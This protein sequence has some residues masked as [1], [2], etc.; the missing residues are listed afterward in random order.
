M[1]SFL[2]KTIFPCYFLDWFI[3]G[4]STWSGGDAWCATAIFFDFYLNALYPLLLI[5]LCVIL[6]TR[7]VPPVLPP[8]RYITPLDSG[9]KLRFLKGLYT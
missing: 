3:V 9:H 6:Y 8:S 5:T 4:L 7:K 2:D 1:E